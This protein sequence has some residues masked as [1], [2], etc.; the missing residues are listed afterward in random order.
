MTQTIGM[1]IRGVRDPERRWVEAP[2]DGTLRLFWPL[3][4]EFFSGAR[5]APRP[6]NDQDQP[7]TERPIWAPPS[8]GASTPDLCPDRISRLFSQ[9]S[10]RSALCYFLAATRGD[11]QAVCLGRSGDLSAR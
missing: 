1:A 3:A 4:R 6:A 5:E 11:G 8:G 10:R 2:P 9:T 7:G